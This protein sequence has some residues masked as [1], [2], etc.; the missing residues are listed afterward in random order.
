[1]NTVG[2]GLVYGSPHLTGYGIPGRS[3][4]WPKPTENRYSMPSS[5]SNPLYNLQM[6][7]S[8]NLMPP[9][10]SENLLPSDYNQEETIDLSSHSVSAENRREKEVLRNGAVLESAAVKIG[11]SVA[12]KVT[13]SAV[14]G[15]F[16]ESSLKSGTNLTDNKD[17]A[18]SV[19][20]QNPLSDVLNCSKADKLECSVVKSGESSVVRNVESLVKNSTNLIV[21]SS[22]LIKSNPE[23]GADSVSP[24][25]LG[26]RSPDFVKSYASTE[27]TAIKNLPFPD[28]VSVKSPER[29]VVK[30]SESFNVRSPERCVKIP[31][32]F[33]IRGTESSVLKIPENYNVKSPES[34][35]KIPENINPRSPE[36]VL[37]EKLHDESPK[38]PEIPTNKLTISDVKS[39]DG[40]PP[41]KPVCNSPEHINV[42]T[43]RPFADLNVSTDSNSKPNE[44]S[45]DISLES[46][47]LHISESSE[48][49][50]K[51]DEAT[52]PLFIKSPER[53]ETIEDV[54]SLEENSN[55][56]SDECVVKNI[57]KITNDWENSNHTAEN[58]ESILENMFNAQDEKP[59]P[60]A[61]QS[62]IVSNDSRSSMFDELRSEKSTIIVPM[63]EEELAETLLE[64][65][66]EIKLEEKDESV[67]KMMDEMH[68]ESEKI[69][70]QPKQEIEKFEESMEV[71]EMKENIP[72][73]VN[74]VLNQPSALRLLHK[75][76]PEN[77]KP[78]I[79]TAVTTPVE[80]NT[81]VESV[82][83]PFIEVE[84]E[85][86]KMFAGIVEPA[87]EAM[88]ENQIMSGAETGVE[89][90]KP[91]TN[92]RPMTRRKTPNRR[93]PD[94]N[95]FGSEGKKKLNKRLSEIDGKK[96]KKTKLESGWDS[97]SGKK[98][99]G[100]Q[101]DTSNDSGS[102]VNKSKGPFIHV[103]GSKENPINVVVVNS[104]VRTEDEEGT[105]KFISRRKHSSYQR[106]EGK[107]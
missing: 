107:F 46:N 10:V 85:L 15:E 57:S 60:S 104:G 92:K 76:L 49:I 6:Q 102:G 70:V 29:T 40:F 93:L 16:G 62:V 35:V 8:Q 30:M 105:E 37:T 59:L 42:E 47:I 5:G 101:K 23:R 17:I 91:F 34:S 24:E 32:H 79:A 95:L 97:P 27:I 82:K 19:I 74:P 96:A 103:E 48:D 61:P 98:G 26:V 52:D 73:A 14:N 86:E 65:S 3:Q 69:E 106:S 67:E 7:L 18:V 88:N 4:Q 68:T 38:S 75:N 44:V 71:E 55:Q 13:E 81:N 41:D 22:E 50:E 33:N 54:I 78:S 51:E 20:A 77:D 63:K 90:K 66:R 11:E 36:S 99:K 28:L 80:I 89:S 64:E 2:G 45:T 94:G 72:K 83:N 1:M 9:V 56:K 39:N 84:S 58:V 43:I 12:V 25:Y 53:A 31:E 100:F 87:G 21:K